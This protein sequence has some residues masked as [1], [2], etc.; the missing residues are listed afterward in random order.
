MGE[1]AVVTVWEHFILFALVSL[2]VALVYSGLRQNDL[3]VI[4]LLGLKRFFIFM[5]ASAVF[6][7]VVYFFALA[8]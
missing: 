6:A 1:E 4:I 7:V 3:K 2:L 8:L 5:G